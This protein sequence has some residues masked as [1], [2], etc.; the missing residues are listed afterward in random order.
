MVRSDTGGRDGGGRRI[1]V[2]P[3][4]C[5][6]ILGALCCSRAAEDEERGAEGLEG[7]AEVSEEAGAAKALLW[8]DDVATGGEVDPR[9]AI[10]EGSAREG[11]RPGETIYV[12]MAVADAPTEAAVHVVFYGASGER[13]AEDEKKVPAAASFLY[14]DSGDTTNWPAGSY[15]VEIFV[16]GEVVEERALT[17][18][19]SAS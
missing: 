1:L 18:L 16:D 6:A 14:F 8:L 12:S 7:V 13:V 11:F 10:A 15:R 19:P 3:A 5:L 17:L 9:G 2:V 4:A